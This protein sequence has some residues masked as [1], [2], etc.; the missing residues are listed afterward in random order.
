MKNGRNDMKKRKLAVIL[1]GLGY[2]CDKPLLY[3]TKKYLCSYFNILKNPII[4]I[5][6][7]TNGKTPL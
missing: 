6:S 4:D 1:P 7:R 5:N 2:H 3:Y